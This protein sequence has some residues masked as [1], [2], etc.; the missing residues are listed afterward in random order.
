M[1]CVRDD[2]LCVFS[3]GFI[4]LRPVACYR[5][6]QIAEVKSPTEK[7]QLERFRDTIDKQIDGL[8]YELYGLSEEEIKIVEGK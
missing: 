8:V 4:I 5:Q 7:K 3:K 2:S 1:R 6:K